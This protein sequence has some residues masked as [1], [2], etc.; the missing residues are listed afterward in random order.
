[1]VIPSDEVVAKSV[2]GKLGNKTLWGVSTVGGLHLV[3]A[4]SP[5]G[6]KQV[7]G[8]GSHRAVARMTAKRMH[9]DIEWSVLEKSQEIDERD[10][11]DILPFWLE[12]VKRAQQKA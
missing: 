1:M 6:S 4:R 11:A 7:I 9:Q 3:E 5:D 12:V 8:A 10:V 2:I